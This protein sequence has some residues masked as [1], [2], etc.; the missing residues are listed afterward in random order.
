MKRLTMATIITWLFAITLTSCSSK[1]DATAPS[2]SEQKPLVVFCVRH[3]EKVD[4]SEDPELS[5]AGLERAAILARSLRSAEIEYVHS[6]DFIRTRDT[7]APTATDHGLEVELYD[8][9]DLPALV[10][11]LREAGGRHLVVGHSG[12][13]PALAE[14]LSG[15]P[16]S[17]INDAGEYDRLYIVTVGKAGEASSVLMRYGKP[18]EPEP[19]Q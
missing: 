11:K 12:S 9:Q 1:P 7:A 18:Y 8:P 3:A 16:S 4:S 15:Q 2:E 19:E 10:E 5:A 14:L 13:T 6:S 17:A